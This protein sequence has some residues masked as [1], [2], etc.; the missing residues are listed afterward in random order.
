MV[1]CRRVERMLKDHVRLGKALLHI[2]LAHLD[3]LEQISFWMKLRLPLL[4]CLHWICDDRLEV[5]LR[6]DQSRRLIRNLKRFRR[7]DHYR[8]PHVP[9]AFSHADDHGPVIDD[10][11]MIVLAFDIFSSEIP[12]QRLPMLSLSTH[13][14][15]SRTHA[16]SLHV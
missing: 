8:I 14:T 11:S 6:L 16:E 5:E 3:V 9:D 7:Y 2:A 15:S 12:Q 13:P 1:G 10:Q 4:T